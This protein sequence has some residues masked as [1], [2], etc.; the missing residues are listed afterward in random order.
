MA[1]LAPIGLSRIHAALS[2]W[3]ADDTRQGY[4][5]TDVHLRVVLWNRWMELHSGHSAAEAVGRSLFDL[6]GEA[7][8]R[9]I[10][11]YYE[12]ALTGRVT[13]I[14]HGLHRYLLSMPP[15][16]KDLPYPQ[17]PQSGHIGPLW[18]GPDVIGTVTVVEDVSD[19]LAS[20][21]E[22]RSQIAA[23]Q[24]A[25]V[26]AEHALRAK[27]DFLSTLSH[28]MRTPLHAVLGWAR[29]LRTRDEVDP[30]LLA[31]ALEI[32]ERN[33]SAQAK[34]I[35]DMLDM[36]RIVAGKLRLEM[37]VVDL[38]SVVLAAVDVVMPSANAR[39]INVRTSLDTA[40][41]PVLGDP[42]RLQQVV[43][44]LLSNA[45]KFTEPGGTIEV[46]LQATTGHARI[47]VSD[48]GQGINQS[49]LPHLFERFRQNDAS[50]TR[51][52]GGLGLG[53][54]LVRELVEL[55]GGTVRAASDGPGKGATF[56]IDLSTAM[57]SSAAR[58]F[59]EAEDAP[60]ATAQ[61]LTGVRVLV[62][63]DESDAR[64]LMVTTMAQC[65][66][67]VI[68]VSSS[69]EAFAAIETAPASQLPHV[70]VSDIGMPGQNG[71]TLIRR[72]RAM[73]PAEGGRIPAISVTGYA[74]AEDIQRA[75]AAGYQRHV[76]KPMDPRALVS[77]VA[78]LAGR[79]S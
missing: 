48:T 78:E 26:T 45:S 67:E 19:R 33:A 63:D 38:A 3:F 46:K 15:T 6:Y 49:F 69:A 51:R 7:A 62:V 68:A 17:M 72:V 71:Y 29:V 50:S 25:R 56:T 77:A 2:R 43:W 41:P 16:Q 74:T 21:A 65:G 11:E 75:I 40:C 35:D 22:L 37:Q 4:V 52:Q 23:Q 64:D 20:E 1:Q 54:A 59:L 66:A 18:D 53:L 70:I 76:S 47:I 60:P 32:I 14:S 12:Q 31:R 24:L 28:E 9:G 27:D 39:R 44:N 42:D 61:S 58:G 73:E 13:V 30:D 10:K 57:S 79:S 5:A 55:H 36:A 8:D 34:M